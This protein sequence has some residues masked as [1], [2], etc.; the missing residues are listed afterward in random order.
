MLKTEIEATTTAIGILT[1]RFTPKEGVF[2]NQAYS[3]LIGLNRQNNPEFGN[4][5]QVLSF[6]NKK[7][8]IYHINRLGVNLSRSIPFDIDFLTRNPDIDQFYFAPFSR[9]MGLMIPSYEDLY[10]LFRHQRRRRKEINSTS[11]NT[12]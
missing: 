4:Q 9:V 6:F 8:Y 1:R 11:K 5:L 12:I 2:L 10:G 7:C 3:I